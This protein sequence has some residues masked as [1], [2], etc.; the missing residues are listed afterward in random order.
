MA[1]AR[2]R[3]RA[4]NNSMTPYGRIGTAGFTLI[5]SILLYVIADIR[6]KSASCP[7][8]SLQAYQGV[9]L[10]ARVFEKKAE[11][12]RKIGSQ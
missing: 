9:R 6:V 7:P 11:F 4:G 3:R 10:E 8:I 5:V 1:K 2:S 12:E